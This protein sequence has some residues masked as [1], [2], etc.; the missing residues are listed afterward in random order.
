MGFGT[1]GRGFNKT[2]GAPVGLVKSQRGCLESQWGRLLM[3]M[4]R[5]GGVK[6]QSNLKFLG[7]R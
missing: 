4:L 2:D 5:G 7:A 3:G 1:I 6:K